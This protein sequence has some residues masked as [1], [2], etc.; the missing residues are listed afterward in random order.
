[1]DKC[2]RCR[3]AVTPGLVGVSRAADGAVLCGSKVCRA[4]IGAPRTPEP[5]T[6]TIAARR[7]SAVA[8]AQLLAAARLTPKEWRDVARV[9]DIY[10]PGTVFE[11]GR[12]THPHAAAWHAL[13]T[14]DDVPDDVRQRAALYTQTM[15]RIEPVDA[16]LEQ[17]AD[18]DIEFVPLAKAAPIARGVEFVPLAK[19]VR[20]VEF[21]PLAKTMRGVEFVPLANTA[22]IGR[23]IEFVPLRIGDEIADLVPDTGTE[24]VPAAILREQEAYVSEFLGAPGTYVMVCDADGR[25]RGWLSPLPTSSN[26]LTIEGDLCVKVLETV[27][28]TRAELGA[29]IVAALNARLR[30]A[31]AAGY[32]WSDGRLTN[33]NRRGAL[34]M[35]YQR[36]MFSNNEMAG[37]G[38]FRVLV[39]TPTP[40]TPLS[41]DWYVDAA[42]VEA[43]YPA[44]GTYGYAVDP[45]SPFEVHSLAGVRVYAQGWFDLANPR[46]LSANPVRFSVSDAA[47][48]AQGGA[49]A[50][51]YCDRTGGG[52]DKLELYD[53]RTVTNY[54]GVRVSVL[55]ARISG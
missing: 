33:A 37:A 23:G 17:A 49:G 20:G 9:L 27:Y 14:R 6:A 18:D 41:N 24:H 21:A 48:A 39:C 47:R 28:D 51:M 40:G 45:L 5:L 4:A 30:S 16:R 7:L 2:A 25:P 42:L 35:A 44:A 15:L 34:T 19:A 10:Y 50:I 11:R 22:S 53:L 8:L 12:Y 31:A 13:E 29:A 46:A 55:L 26:W 3:T 54:D 32:A 36:T 52:A 38:D 43:V 1:M